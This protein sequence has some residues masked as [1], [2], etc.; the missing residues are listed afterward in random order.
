MNTTARPTTEPGYLAILGL[1]RAPFLDR[2]DDRFFYADPALIQRLDLLRHLTQFGDML[3]A[4]VGPD[5]S[6][7][8]TLLQQFMGYGDNAWRCCRIDAAQIGQPDELLARLA[9]GFE[10]DLQSDP[11]RLVATLHRH[12]QALRHTA[13]LPVIVVD[14]AQ[15]LPDA[16]LKTLLTLGGEPRET[17]KQVR[18]VL[19]ATPGLDQRLIQAG[20]HDPQRPLLHSL[21]VPP[22]D[23]QQ[24]AAYLMYR[25][26]VAGYS[27]DSPFSLTEIRALHK[28]AGGRP[29]PLNLLAHEAL[30][31]RAERIA[32]GGADPSLAARRRW[33]AVLGAGLGLAA[34]G[35][36][37]SHPSQLTVPVPAAPPR[38]ERELHLRPPPPEP[39]AETPTVPEPAAELPPRRED[40]AAET[41]TAVP[42]AAESPAPPSPAPAETALPEALAATP[43]EDPA[44]TASVPAPEPSA[45]ETALSAPE[46][47]PS[48][49]ETALSAPETASV[50]AAKPAPSAPLPTTAPAPQAPAV[51]ADAPRR[52]DWLRSRPAGHFT[53]QLLG[54][55]SEAALHAYLAE[56]SPP[57]PVAYFRTVFKGGDWYVLVQGDYPSRAA[58]RAAVATLPTALRAG[59]PWPRSFA[60]IHDELK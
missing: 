4:I 9:T 16:A 15:R 8:T 41:E 53:L 60:S 18:I 42:P 17:L 44:E 38:A 13:R 58:A 34:L 14:D 3:L 57:G 37:L 5:G 29:G 43:A 39:V 10:Q 32:A 47:E 11:Q 7:K 6:G 56:H 1:Q 19:F 52:E 12:F 28:A 20:L 23:V 33:A 45:P 59:K 50:P 55:R 51:A 2:V 48:A 26:A 25:L 54:V 31:E 46:P 21:E 35:W 22:F 24:S 30:L 36:Y 27:G 49:P 40:T